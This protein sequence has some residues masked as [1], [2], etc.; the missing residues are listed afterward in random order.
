MTLDA[1]TQPATDG[2]GIFGDKASVLENAENENDRADAEPEGAVRVRSASPDPDARP[3]RDAAEDHRQD[4]EGDVPGGVE[5]KA[6]Q[7]YVD[8]PESH[9]H[10]PEQR[11]GDTER[12]QIRI[13]IELHQ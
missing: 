1:P 4:E 11:H 13:G 2:H 6:Q 10:K 9:R 5:G 7:Q 3:E 8:A 12:Q